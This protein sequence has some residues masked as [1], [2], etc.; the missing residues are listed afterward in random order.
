[1]SASLLLRPR[2]SQDDFSWLQ[3]LAKSVAGG[4]QDFLS[5]PTQLT[6]LAGPV[7]KSRFSEW[8]LTQ[9]TFGIL[10]PFEF[11]KDADKIV[12]FI[13]GP[14]VTQT[15][16]LHYGGS[17]AAPVR[18][19]LTPSELRFLSR[20]AASLLPHLDVTNT[21]AAT[22]PA[23]PL[24]MQCDVAGLNWPRN[25]D[26]IIVADIQIEGPAIAPAT[27]SCFIGSARAKKL[28]A[29]LAGSNAMQ[30]PPQPEWQAKMRFAAH[31][32]PLPARA[33]LTQADFP[34]SRLLALQAGDI[35]P[36]MLPTEVPLYV[37][38]RRFAHGSIGAS[39]GRNALR[40]K[41]M[42]GP[43]NE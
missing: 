42:E 40:I 14:L 10:L 30:L 8:C 9:S 1:M 22:H 34:L 17:G 5:G 7:S 37:A 2:T 33:V 11:G 24:E 13:P 6:A 41:Y 19:G 35:L 31:R 43:I 39:N 20:L 32:V 27:I 4:L 16:D 21:D 28:A 25:R 18:E 3:L 38:G 12:I 29:R 26:S 15:L 23:R 36:V